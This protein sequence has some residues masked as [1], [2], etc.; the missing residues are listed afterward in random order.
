MFTVA[1][2]Y[3]ADQDLSNDVFIVILRQS[4]IFILLTAKALTD[5]YFL[6]AYIEPRWIKSLKHI[7]R[8]I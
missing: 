7:L 3:S 1:Y 5:V 8:D 4:L 2:L 6:T